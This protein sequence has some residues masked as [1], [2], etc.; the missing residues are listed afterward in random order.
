MSEWG[1]GPALILAF[2][3]MLVI[4][5]VGAFISEIIRQSRAH[6]RAMRKFLASLPNEE[7]SRFAV[8]QDLKDLNS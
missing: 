1:W 5:G 8:M 7:R 2:G 3:I 6:K 4:L